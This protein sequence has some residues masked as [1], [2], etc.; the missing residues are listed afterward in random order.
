MTS[1]FGSMIW[2]KLNIK[3]TKI[4][5]RYSTNQESQDLVL[6]HFYFGVERIKTTAKDDGK[7][8]STDEPFRPHGLDLDW[9][10][11]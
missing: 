1:P 5:Y 2:E 8:R 10:R 11:R 7:V 3:A 9:Y 6:P 4:R